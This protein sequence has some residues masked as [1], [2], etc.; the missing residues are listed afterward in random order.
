M[1]KKPVITQPAKAITGTLA[2]AILLA[3]TRW[4]SYIGFAPLFLTDVLIALA[5]VDRVLG[6]KAQARQLNGIDRPH[7][8]PIVAIFLAYVALRGLFSVDFAFS[9]AW[10]RDLTPFL[11][12]VL[13]FLSASA[14]ARSTKTEQLKTMKFLWWA[15]VAHLVWV[16]AV[17]FSG[18]ET[19]AF[20]RFPGAAVPVFTLRPDVD[21]AVIG[22]T[23]GLAVRRI[24]LGE[25]RKVSILL[26]AA[27]LAT[28]TQFGSRAGLISVAISMAAGLL[29]AFSS[30][31]KGGSKRVLIVLLIPV[32]ALAGFAGLAQT[33]AGERLIA[34]TLATSTS[35]AHERNAQGTQQAREMSWDG[36][37]QWTMD[38]TSRA[39]GGSGFGNDFLTES[40]VIQF[41]QGTD[42]IGVR[43]P[44]N[45]LVGVFARLGLIGVALA[46]TILVMLVASVIR[47][48][49]R[50][51]GNE[52]L[53]AASL[54]VLGFIPIALLGV[55]LESPFG[56]VPFWWA[57]GIVLALGRGA[58][59]PNRR[60]LASASRRRP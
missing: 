21:V 38:D 57:A 8:G 23:A 26:L 43:S 35:N 54:I 14:L 19:S 7:P 46:A 40:G 50:I 2:V 16:A 42:Y 37:I 20:P 52:M 17:V 22:V 9:M 24:L 41:L 11:Y 39:L 18:V 6:Q 25:R 28:T 55:V 51:G 27:C 31:P 5:V 45:W 56:A 53:S 1:L 4:G 12:A 44:H 15:L 32:I 30:L 29:I 60:D 33:T 48:R 3:G 47:F 10:L 13:A 34:S 49:Q 36:I 59:R 58:T